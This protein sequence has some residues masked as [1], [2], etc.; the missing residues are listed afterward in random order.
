M[1]WIITNAIAKILQVSLTKWLKKLLRI[2]VSIE[3]E[4]PPHSDDGLID[5]DR[6][7]NGSSTPPDEVSGNQL[8]FDPDYPT[9]Q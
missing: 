6:Y 1:R 9:K 7:V 8:S 5:Q 3:I 4:I 2:D